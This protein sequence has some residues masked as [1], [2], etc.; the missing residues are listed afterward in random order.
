MCLCCHFSAVAFHLAQLQFTGPRGRTGL[1][2]KCSLWKVRLCYRDCHGSGLHIRRIRDRQCCRVELGRRTTDRCCVLL[3]VHNPDDH[4]RH[5]HN[6]SNTA[7]DNDDAPG[8]LCVRN[9]AAMYTHSCDSAVP[10][11]RLIAEVGLASLAALLVVVLTLRVGVIE[12]AAR[13]AQLA[14]RVES[15]ATPSVT[16]RMTTKSSKKR[17]TL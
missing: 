13:A 7:A 6:H 9:R 15:R 12:W 8:P 16:T 17:L 11:Q 14:T 10:T 4:G 1:S 2:A 5:Y 3:L